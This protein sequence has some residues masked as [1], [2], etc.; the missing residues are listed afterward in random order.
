MCPNF[1]VSM[2]ETDRKIKRREKIALFLLFSILGI[3]FRPAGVV[4]AVQAI[5][6]ST[7]HTTDSSHN[8]TTFTVVF[9]SDQT[10]YAFYRDSGGQ[11]SYRKTLDGGTTWSSTT[12][13]IDSQTD[14]LR[15]AVWYDQWTP[16]N[17][18]GTIIHL[19]TIDSGADDIWYTRFNVASDT[20]STPIPISA[21]QGGTYAVGTN[22]QAITRATDGTIYAAVM[23]AADS[24]MLGC[25]PNASNTNCTATSS[26]WT[27]KGAG[28]T[29]FGVT[30]DWLLLLPISSGNVMVTRNVLADDTLDWNIWY[31]SSSSWRTTSSAA[32][33][34]IDTCTN[35]T[36]YDG[37]FG[38]TLNKISGDIYMISACDVSTL[39]TN[40]DIRTYRFYNS[41]STWTSSTAAVLTNTTYGVTGAKIGLDANTGNIYAVYSARTTANTANTGNVYYK[42]STSTMANWGAEQ[43]PLN[44]TTTDVYGLRIDGM[45]NERMYATWVNGAISYLMGNTVA[46]LTPTSYEQTS[47]KFFSNQNATSVGSELGGQ[48]TTGVVQ[49]GTPFRL[50]SLIH[51]GGDGTDINRDYYKL[52]YA[53]TT[54]GGCD[55]SFSGETYVD[56]ATSTGDIRFYDNSSP[57]NGANLQATSTDPTHGS[58][59][60]V[61]QTYVEANPFSNSA[62]KIFGGQDGKWDFSL[63]MATSAV[64]SAYC[65]RMVHEEE[66]LFDTYTYIPEIQRNSP[67]TVG[68]VHFNS[69]Q[70][71]FLTEGTST[72]I[73]ATTTVSDEN[74][75][76]DIYNAYGK[77]YRSGVGGSCSQND[78]NCYID[79]LC[80]INNCG[81]NSC[82]ATCRFYIQFH[83]DPTDT[84]TP[85]ASENWVAQIY[86]QD[87]RGTTS[88]VAT[89]SQEI[90]TLLAFAVTPT[91]P[92][93]D[94]N[95]GSTTNPLA[96]TTTIQNTGNGSADVNLYGTNMTA[97]PNNI[98]VG[99]QKYATSSAGYATSTSLLVNPGVNI[100]LNI[101]KTTAT[102]SRATSTLFWGI[103]VPD[104]QPTGNYTG[105]N[106]FIAIL[107]SL[108][109]P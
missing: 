96:P 90:Y 5:I 108:P 15:I 55:T 83:A 66:A 24:Y 42:V 39:G 35:N 58:D 101:R 6:D 89:S 22:L 37:H 107:N 27:E 68:T 18:T 17:T 14:C 3:I 109:W 69:D 12:V 7:V 78:N 94:L 43:G 76:G 63:I 25:L 47:Y 56:V 82:L 64:Y 65:F 16:G 106:A 49:E 51:V 45:N 86:G 34:N 41:S 57:L 59:T 44:T 92:Y 74:G 36:T 73:I 20:A 46:D 72:L 1:C 40:D 32:W 50:R 100:D 23:D 60:I 53:S 91:I 77:A 13:N 19:L 102:S 29:V 84:D 2:L 103:S 79:N 93:G 81:G 85:W 104:P 71:I 87:N 30:N 10:G 52:Q 70:D 97:G 48:N 95:P 11:C 28:T 99:Q 33:P 105:T 54:G 62:A 4:Y 38:A 31:N 8:G 88:T 21:S 61:N 26:N 98:P 75:F 67:P 9:T 80:Q